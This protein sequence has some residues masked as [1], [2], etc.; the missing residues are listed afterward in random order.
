[1]SDSQAPTETKPMTELE[2]RRAELEKSKQEKA[3]LEGLIRF[4]KINIVLIEEKKL[5]EEA[6]KKAEL[7][8]KEQERL[9]KLT[10]AEALKKQE[11]EQKAKIEGLIISLLTNIV[12]I[13][14][15]RKKAELDKSKITDQ[16]G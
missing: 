6:R 16:T 10:D 9:K 12:P 4:F 15:A 13:E 5:A 2:K 11:M 8:K 3:K 1:L 7:E 14:E